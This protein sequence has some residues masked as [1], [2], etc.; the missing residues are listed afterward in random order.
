MIS[1]QSIS[2]YT[3]VRQHTMLLIDNSVLLRTESGI[4]SIQGK[5][6]PVSDRSQLNPEIGR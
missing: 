2:I 1:A 4:P 5:Y 6:A 3:T